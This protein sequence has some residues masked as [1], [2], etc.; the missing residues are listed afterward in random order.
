VSQTFTFPYHFFLGTDLQTKKLVDIY[1]PAVPVVIAYGSSRTLPFYA[2]VDSGADESLFPAS[3]A[4]EIGIDLKKGKKGKSV[5]IGK[6]EIP[7]YT[8][9]VTLYFYKFD[10]QVEIDFAENHQIALLGRKGFFDLFKR[11]S[12]H[13]KKK[14]IEFKI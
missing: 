6:I 3:L 7:C 8:H 9:K 2:H 13:E 4:F 1:R 12:F 14:H 5:G 10:F 11:V